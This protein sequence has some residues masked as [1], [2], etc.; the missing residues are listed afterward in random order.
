[1]SRSIIVPRDRLKSITS[2]D[3]RKWHKTFYRPERMVLAVAGEDHDRV[4]ESVKQ[5]FQF[6]PLEPVNIPRLPPSRFVSKEVVLPP[7]PK[8]KLKRHD[9]QLSHLMLG[10]EGCSFHNEDLYALTVLH[11]LL[12]GGGSFSSGGPGKGM[13]SRLYRNVLNGHANIDSANSFMMS[14]VDTG[15]FGVYLHMDW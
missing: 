10:W 3:L 8:E 13:Y 12:G 4:V 5:H 2:E 14:Y 6:G 1:M 9:K 15:L 7:D 11:T